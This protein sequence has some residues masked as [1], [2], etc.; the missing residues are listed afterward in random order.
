MQSLGRS[1]RQ[2]LS[3]GLRQLHPQGPDVSGHKQLSR[4]CSRGLQVMDVVVG[5]KTRC[6]KCVE[7][8]ELGQESVRLGSSP[9]S[10]FCVSLSE[11][12]AFSVRRFIV[13]YMMGINRNPITSLA[14]GSSSLSNN[15]LLILDNLFIFSVSQFLLCKMKAGSLVPQ[16]HCKSKWSSQGHGLTLVAPNPW[17]EIL[18]LLWR[19]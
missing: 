8:G 11:D 19:T 1:Q 10:A 18:Q 12:L 14:Q 6:M 5:R 7:C 13:C 16:G 9:C 3:C 4:S 2:G 17:K 15:L